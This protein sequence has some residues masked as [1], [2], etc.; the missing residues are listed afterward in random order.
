MTS[1]GWVWTYYPIEDKELAT[2]LIQDEK[3]VLMDTGVELMATMDSWPKF[4]PRTMGFMIF[5]LQRAPATGRVHLQ[6]YTQFKCKQ[7]K[8]VAMMKHKA[9]NNF[10]ME[11]QKGTAEDN[12]KYIEDDEK[13]TNI[14]LGDVMLIKKEGTLDENVEG[15]VGQGARTDIEVVREAIKDRKLTVEELKKFLLS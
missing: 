8:S 7:G 12:R 13:K 5:S 10:W 4:N 6:G 2:G 11:R 1:Q 14:I 3:G 15:S 9:K